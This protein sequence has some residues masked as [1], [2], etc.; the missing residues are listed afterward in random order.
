[1][2]KEQVIRQKIQ[3]LVKEF[4][5][6]KHQAKTFIPG[7]SFIPY[8][9]RV[10]DE[11]EIQALVDSSLDFWLTLGPEGIAFEKRLA[12]YI[13]VRFC[14]L[15]NSGS[16]ANLIAFGALTS[17]LLGDKRILPGSEV[18]T[19]AAGFPTTV[20]PIMQ[21]NCVPVFVDVTEDTKNVDISYLEKAR[22]VKTRAVMMAHT[23]GNPFDL[24][25]VL[26]F[27][28]KYNLFLIEDNCDA[29]G[30]EY[31]GKK[32]GS[33]GH[34]A[35][36][37][38]YPAHQM[39]LGEGGAVLTNDAVIN[40]AIRSLRD[41]GK[42]CWCDSGKDNTCGKRFSAQHGDLPA[43]YDHKY[44]YSHIGYNLKPT[45]L[46]AAI[47]RVQLDKLPS[48]VKARKKNFKTFYKA[49]KKYEDYFILPK[50]TDGSDPCWFGFLL[51]IRDDV[52]LKREDIVD[53]LEGR[54]IQTRVLFAGN[55]VKQPL[56]DEFRGDESKY[57][58]VG[59]L[60]NTDNIM[61]KTFW[62]GVYPGL[63]QEHTA[64]IIQSFEEF[65]AT[66]KAAV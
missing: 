45:D 6:T 40:K 21:Y 7:E 20:A 16:S 1:M 14:S 64:Y 18:I 47:G 54:K 61:N 5:E 63:T 23:L 59:D 22:T 43:G 33:F 57:R 26:T 62:F 10:F 41:W 15:V 66:K 28:E 30:S 34:V 46:Q 13:G 65:F 9:G 24:D 50:A 49:L 8:A 17:Y 11:K 4:Y 12:K 51:T 56:F 3:A 42:D 39:T 60:K 38:F 27:C 32:T 29:L 58:V 52:D 2:D 25:A 31:K 55:L 36:E 44:V 19:I 35:T 37:S 53:F 48:F